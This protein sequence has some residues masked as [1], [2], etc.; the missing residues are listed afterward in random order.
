MLREKRDASREGRLIKLQSSQTIDTHRGSLKHADIIGKE[1]RQIVNSSKGSSFRVHE[2]TLSD[3]VRLT[4]RLVTPVR[5]GSPDCLCVV[6]LTPKRF[7]PQ[8]PT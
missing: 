8:T 2:P 6:E 5:Q 1:P 3:Y 7:I 4:P